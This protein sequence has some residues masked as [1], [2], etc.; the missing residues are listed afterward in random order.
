MDLKKGRTKCLIFVTAQKMKMSC[1]TVTLQKPPKYILT[2]VFSN[3]NSDTE[4]SRAITA[5]TFQEC[6]IENTS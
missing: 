4:L 1:E 3:T 5:I 6:K 2:D